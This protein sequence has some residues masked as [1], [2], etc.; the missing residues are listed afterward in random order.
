MENWEKLIF[1]IGLLVFIII[2]YRVYLICKIKDED[3]EHKSKL[4]E[5]KKLNNIIDDYN[6]LY[7]SQ[8]SNYEGLIDSYKRDLKFYKEKCIKLEKKLNQINK[9]VYYETRTFCTERKQAK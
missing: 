1:G 7:K 4:S 6:F 8:E 5:I 2:F 9:N 3:E